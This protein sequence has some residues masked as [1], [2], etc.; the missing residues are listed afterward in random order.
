MEED[1]EEEEAKCL[2]FFSLPQRAGE[3]S[4]NCTGY[5]AEWGELSRPITSLHV[6]PDTNDK[7]SFHRVARMCYRQTRI[8]HF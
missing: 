7:G 2:L 5:G 1:E 3:K 6:E 8:V 4:K